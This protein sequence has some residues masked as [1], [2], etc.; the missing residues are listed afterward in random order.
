MM[1]VGHLLDVMREDMKSKRA[2]ERA[3]G[4]IRPRPEP[5]TKRRRH[6]R[7]QTKRE[8]ALKRA[9]ELLNKSQKVADIL[10]RK[11]SLRTVRPEDVRSDW[12]W[13]I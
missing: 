4:V 6:G 9:E 13:G 2:I 5:R 11:G 1:K 12:V 8:L 7:K 3:S 10:K